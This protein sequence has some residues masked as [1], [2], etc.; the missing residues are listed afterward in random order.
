MYGRTRETYTLTDTC[1]YL[2]RPAWG[3][4]KPRCRLSNQCREWHAQGDT[5][6]PVSNHG[7]LSAF[8][9]SNYVWCLNN[10]KFNRQQQNI[11]YSCSS[12]GPTEC[13]LKWHENGPLSVK[14]MALWHVLTW[15]GHSPIGV[16]YLP[17]Q[18]L[19]NTN[20][21]AKYGYTSHGYRR[22]HFVRALCEVSVRWE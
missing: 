20:P 17:T 14:I 2:Y 16:L 18:S 22:R 3:G 13:Q 21:Y 19:Y 12:K 5:P 6:R 8:T 9:V 15:G 11:A 7:S 10:I 1:A 4:H